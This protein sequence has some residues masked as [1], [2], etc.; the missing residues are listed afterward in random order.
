MRLN[1]RW[2]RVLIIGALAMMLVLGACSSGGEQDG[3]NESGGRNGEGEQVAGAN[4]VAHNQEG[5]SDDMLEEHPFHIGTLYTQEEPNDFLRIDEH[6]Y[7]QFLELRQEEAVIPAMLQ[8]YVPQ[9]ITLIEEQDW[10]VITN[11]SAK[12]GRPT[13]LTV[14]DNVTGEFIKVFEL[15]ETD[16]SAYTGH[17]GGITVTDQY[18][19]V[20][21]GSKVRRVQTEKLVHGEE[22][23]L[24][25]EDEFIVDSRASF[26]YADDE[27]LWVGD[28]ALGAN[29]PTPDTHHMLNRE[30]KEH[31]GWIAGYVLDEE[32]EVPVNSLTATAGEAARPDY[33]LSIPDKVQGMVM[34]DDRII[35]STSYGR[36]NPSALLIYEHVLHTEPHAQ[37]ED[38]YDEAIP[39]WFLDGLSQT[40][41]LVMPPASETLVLDEEKLYILFESGANLYRVSGSYPLL[42]IQ[43]IERELLGQLDGDEIG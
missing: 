36:S 29:Y 31:K 24:T 41:E 7:E 22:P 1:R 30:G 42:R 8:D 19:W 17:A 32:T 14:I 21:S 43:T 6:L 23:K 27:V 5:D 3:R 40:G 28:F 26:V 12:E 10:L 33:I 15:Y 20:A 39:L 34:M 16:G 13:I 25:F 11:Y 4:D 35:L 18:L 2:Y 9:G 37:L 38:V